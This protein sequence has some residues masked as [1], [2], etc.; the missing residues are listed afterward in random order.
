M[1][2]RTSSSKPVSVTLFGPLALART[3]TDTQTSDTQTEPHLHGQWLGW[4]CCDATDV[5]L[6]HAFV[7]AFSWGLAGF[8][9]TGVAPKVSARYVDHKSS[10][11]IKTRNVDLQC[12]SIPRASVQK[13]RKSSVYLDSVPN[14]ALE[15][16]EALAS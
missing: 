10:Q 3:C 14:C 15:C 5:C 7:R 8:D 1:E 2:S 13:T 16:N 4:A 9:V 6:V 12:F 11:R